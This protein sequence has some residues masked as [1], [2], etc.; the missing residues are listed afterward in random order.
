M[1][2]NSLGHRQDQQPQT[3]GWGS[4]DKLPFHGHEL[5]AAVAAAAAGVAVAG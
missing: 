3:Q 1:L 5:H 4:D 2:P